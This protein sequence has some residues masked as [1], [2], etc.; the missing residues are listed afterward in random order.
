VARVWYAIAVVLL[1]AGVAGVI[2][3]VRQSDPH[4]VEVRFPGSYEA[5]GTIAVEHAGPH[6]IWADG[7]P[8]VDA[9]RCVV[10][11]PSGEA[12]SVI[13]PDRHVDWVNRGED[14]AVYTWIAS[15]DAPTAGT[16]S[17]RC[18]PDP[19]APGAAYLVSEGRP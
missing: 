12:V 15:F 2:L 17:I 3:L 9:G 5:T 19:K 14:D 7:G 6:A 11:A 1:V 16:Y 8:P 13:K 4:L 18:R 10:K